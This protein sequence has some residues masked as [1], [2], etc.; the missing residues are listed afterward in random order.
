MLLAFNI[1]TFILTVVCPDFFS[2]AVLE[3]VFPFA[4]VPGTIL[5]HI[6]SMTI[7]LIIQPLAFKDISVDMPEFALTAS[8]IET[9][10]T[11]VLSAVL[12]NLLSITVFHVAKPLT[13]VGGTVLEMNL[14]S[15]FQ[16]GLIDVIHVHGAGI[17]LVLL[18]KVVAASVAHVVAVLRV[19][20]T[21]LC[22]NA[23]TCDHPSTP[24]LQPYHNIDVLGE[25][26][27]YQTSSSDPPKLLNFFLNKQINSVFTYQLFLCQLHVGLY[28]K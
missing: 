24:C 12:P 16:L 3:I 19:H 22:T 7:G 8:F 13:R 18:V 2:E 26:T 21:E 25:V 9:P 4:F 23:F 6:H 10:V 1:V 17:V 27:L 11:F 20:L 14:A 28:L 15:V 5:M